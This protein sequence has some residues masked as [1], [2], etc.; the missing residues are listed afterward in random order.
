[1]NALSTIDR[2]MV[3]SMNREIP[4][5]LTTDEIHQLL[6][7]CNDKRNHLII[8]MLWQTG[9]RVSE[10]L[11]LTRQNI[12]FN[13]RLIKFITLKQRKNNGKSHKKQMERV[14]PIN[15]DLTTEIATFIAEFNP[16]ERL[17][18]ITRVQVFNILRKLS[19]ETGIR[20]EIHP[21]TLRHSFAVHTLVQGVP[22]PVVS[23]L[24]G[25]SQISTT[26]VYL[27][28]VQPDIKN[29]MSNV[30]F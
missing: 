28:I 18:T 6:D 12:D 15:P 4:Q 8:N 1:M 16:T 23:G 20:K 7:S 27:K 14:I 25:H 29:M 19:K 30:R 9:A 5:Y 11:A 13:N 2:R 24:L 22:L 21:H 26:L 10:L 3:M 17:F